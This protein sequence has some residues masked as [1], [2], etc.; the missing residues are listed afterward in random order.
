[1]SETNL[2]DRPVM[3]M[4]TVAVLFA[5]EDSH[6]KTLPQCDVYDLSLIHI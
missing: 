4:V 1:M 5:R 3:Q 2:I 6:Y